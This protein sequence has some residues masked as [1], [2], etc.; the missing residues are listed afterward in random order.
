M[1][2]DNLPKCQPRVQER[3]SWML[4]LKTAGIDQMPAG[5]GAAWQAHEAEGDT[6]QGTGPA[7][8]AAAQLGWDCALPPQAKPLR[9][10]PPDLV[11]PGPLRMWACMSIIHTPDRDSRNEIKIVTGITLQ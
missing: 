11:L 4:D 5:K 8:S 9:P 2:A 3:T 10:F 6:G 7:G 1:N